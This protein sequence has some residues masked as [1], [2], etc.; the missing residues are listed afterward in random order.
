[1]I[2]WKEFPRLDTLE[3]IK[4]L[5]L[6][7]DKWAMPGPCSILLQNPS[8]ASDQPLRLYW[9]GCHMRWD[10][11]TKLASKFSCIS[12]IFSSTFSSQNLASTDLLRLMEFHRTRRN[13][14]MD[15]LE[16]DTLVSPDC[17]YNSGS[18]ARTHQYHIFKWRFLEHMDHTPP[19]QSLAENFL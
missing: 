11:V 14:T 18:I 7:A 10:E 19:G 8:F 12:Q 3:A 13:L 15:Y 16:G 4:P 1:M 17:D 2:T 6:A 5:L 9:L